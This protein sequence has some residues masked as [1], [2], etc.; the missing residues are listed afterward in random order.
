MSN[1]GSVV[2][3]GLLLVLAAGVVAAQGPG[4]GFGPGE[5][6]GDFRAN[7]PVTGAPFSATRT[8]TEVQ[9]LSDGTTI[10]HTTVIKEARDS[11]GRTYTETLPESN[12][13]QARSFVR[14]FDPVNR[15]SINWSSASKQASVLHLPDANDARPAGQGARPQFVG[16]QGRPRPNAPQFTTESLGSKTIAG[17][18]ADGT[19]TTRVIPAG[20]MGNDQAI[21]ITHESWVSSDL[22][23]ELMRVDSDPRFGTTTTEVTGVSRA[24]PAA[25]LFQ[26][27]AGYA[28]QDRYPGQ[29]PARPEGPA[30]DMAP[31]IAPAPIDR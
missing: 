10:T 17:V 28:L 31:G 8:V 25:S 30:P 11:N 4:R 23:L 15:V 2:C 29:R 14:V 18:V 16:P 1:R 9:K 19:R 22:K 5:R 20:K 21:T 6:F 3:A 27:P 7:Q 24:E 26:A 12:S 13:G